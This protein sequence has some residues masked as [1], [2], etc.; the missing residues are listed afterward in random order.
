M[1]DWFPRPDYLSPETLAE[2][3]R[4]TEPERERNLSEPHTFSMHSFRVYPS[5]WRAV[6]GSLR[7]G[8]E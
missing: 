5:P 6:E 2:I 7:E 4:R 1:R 8:W 3:N